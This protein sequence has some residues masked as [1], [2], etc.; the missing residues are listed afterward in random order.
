MRELSDSVGDFDELPVVVRATRQEVLPYL[1]FRHITGVKQWEPLAKARYL[2]QLFDMTN[3]TAV[4]GDRYAEVANAIG[5]RRDHVKRNL[6]A[7][8]VY[9]VI[10][11]QD[12]FEID[13]LGEE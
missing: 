10:E 5:S 1:G 11:Q 12:F 2:K 9:E 7:L 13:E 8:A 3:T 6:D 4:P